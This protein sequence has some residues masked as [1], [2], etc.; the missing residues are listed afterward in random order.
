VDISGLLWGSIPSGV[1]RERCPFENGIAHRIWL[2]G[3]GVDR[4]YETRWSVAYV[5][6]AIS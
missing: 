5:S 1:V 6:L 4:D 2:G 3:G